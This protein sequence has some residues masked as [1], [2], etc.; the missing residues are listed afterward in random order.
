MNAQQLCIKIQFC[1]HPEKDGKMNN[2][3]P[4]KK[5]F[6]KLIH[7]AFLKSIP[8]SFDHNWDHKTFISDVQMQL[9]TLSS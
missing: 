2:I 3:I 9:H 4:S 5:P 8:S 1:N 7:R 6:Y